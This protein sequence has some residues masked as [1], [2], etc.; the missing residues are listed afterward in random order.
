LTDVGVAVERACGR[1]IARS[2]P[3]HT[4]SFEP[5]P[6][7]ERHGSALRCDVNSAMHHP[8][9]CSLDSLPTKKECQVLLHVAAR[10]RR[11]ALR[12]AR[13]ASPERRQP[14]LRR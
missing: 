11:R 2:T 1:V 6:T 5:P 9:G 4:P 7:L 14:I 13:V 3:L 12:P 8:H 10:C